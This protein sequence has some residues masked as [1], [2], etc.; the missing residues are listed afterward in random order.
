MRFRHH[1]LLAILALIL[2]PAVLIGC[3]GDEDPVAPQPS[4]E[5]TEPIAGHLVLPAGWTGDLSS[6]QVASSQGVAECGGTGEFTA[7]VFREDRQLVVVAGDAGPLLTSWFG[8]GG[9]EISTRTTAEV[10]VW[11]ALGSWML[12]ADGR[13]AVRTAISELTTELDPLIAA[14]DQA[15]LDNPTGLPD[16][17]PAVAAAVQDFVDDLLAQVEAE[18][19]VIIE[20]AV[21]Q[22]GVEI[23]NEGG[24]NK[25]MVKNSYRRRSVMFI[26]Q[27]A[28]MDS[29]DM[30]HELDPDSVIAQVEIPPVDGFAGAL[31]TIVGMFFGVLPYEPQLQGPFELPVYPQARETYY[32]FNVLGF[33][34][35]SPED[36][37]LYT[38]AELEAGGWVAMK[39]LVLDYFLP[40]VI[41]MLGAVG[42]DMPLDGLLGGDDTIELAAYLQFI[43]M[44]LPEFHAEVS[45]RNWSGA[46]L[47]LYNSA[48]LNAEFQGATLD[49]IS[50]R[51]VN[52]T[53]DAAQVDKI[54]KGMKSFNKIIGTADIIGYLAD[55]II[56]GVHFENC[57]EADHW[58][59]TVSAPVI[60]IEPREATIETH[61]N[62]LLRCVLDDDTGGPPTGA[63]YAYNWSS[64][65]GTG[66]LIN[67]ADPSDTSND[68][69][70]SHDELYFQADRGVAG[71]EEVICAVHYK[72]GSEYTYIAADTMTV[73]VTR[74]EV[75]LPDTLAFCGEDE[76]TL[77]PRLDPAYTGDE[78]V[79]WSWRSSGLAGT[80]T[81]PAGQIGSW[82]H[83][84]SPEG[85][86]ASDA[87]GG[88]GRLECIASLVI[89]G[90]YSP[91][92]TATVHITVGAVETYSGEI[93]GD[94]WLD[95]SG[96]SG[97]WKVW[98]R[99]P[100]VGGATHY[101]IHIFN[102]Y[103][104]AGYYG[105][106]VNGYG[107]PF[108]IRGY[109]TDSEVYYYLCGGGGSGTAPP[110]DSLAWG[111]S[112]F[113]GAI[114]E[115]TPN[116][117][118]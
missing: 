76:I 59:L 23:L 60:H 40:M 98:L 47:A 19:G 86:Y 83:E 89:D 92:D 25:V 73:E 84:T 106:E 5:P 48:W 87:T 43:A 67:P 78:E 38:S 88:S 57:R 104:H 27:V 46:V 74:R 49:F 72:V 12:P 26:R 15:I 94:A 81:G 39:T 41:N 102:F 79:V 7:E 20:P 110:W 54:L 90:V 35:H 6:L 114:S 71:R 96:E 85:T 91:V 16:E 117:P 93:V 10:A 8:A 82:D 53:V 99:F 30:E 65:G 118:D 28:W 113:D 112:R 107:P 68:F 63:A 103:D 45:N 18:K 64:S 24:I 70:T 50:M 58:E 95:P 80:L 115:I 1:A 3:G 105:T 56:Q 61:H 32:D 55:D 42:T 37:E 34:M 44:N 29:L 62:V 2:I 51:L 36:P 69:M 77:T 100:K 66:V 14:F 31:N 17:C 101:H 97:G 109:E 22:S 75:V 13:R 116:C 9:S 111:L 33:G 11:H 21:Q 4:P 52:S 108:P